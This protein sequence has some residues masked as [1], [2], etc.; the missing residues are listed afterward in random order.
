MEELRLKEEIDILDK[1]VGKWYL[2]ADINR[3]IINIGKIAE[4]MRELTYLKYN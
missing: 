2:S 1:L 3:P 4:L